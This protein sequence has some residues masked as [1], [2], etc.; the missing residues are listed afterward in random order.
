MFIRRS[1]RC[2]VDCT[3]KHLLVQSTAI[4]MGFA[5]KAV[6]QIQVKLYYKIIKTTLSE[7]DQLK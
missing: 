4:K 7:T 2:Q 6:C 5:A 1:E 3:S